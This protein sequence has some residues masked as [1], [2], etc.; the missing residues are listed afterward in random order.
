VVTNQKTSWPLYSCIDPESL[1]KLVRYQWDTYGQKIDLL[2]QD[3]TEIED[4]LELERIM[5][6]RPRTQHD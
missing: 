5:K 1:I 6:E 2:H 3:I 4:D